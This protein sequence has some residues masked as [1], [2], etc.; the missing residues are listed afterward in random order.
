[1]EDALVFCNREQWHCWLSD[2]HDKVSSV[3][4]VFYKKCS[5]KSGITLDEAVEEALRFG[6]IDSRQ[7][8]RNQETFV[9]RFSPRKE[10]SLWSKINKARAEKLIASGKMTESGLK[11]IEEAQKNGYWENAYTNLTS[12]SLPNDLKDALKKDIKAWNN[13]NK[14]A[15]S[16]RN[17]Y[18]FWINQA[19][20]PQTRQKRIETVVEKSLKNIKLLN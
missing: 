7:R 18:I 16:Y 20:T 12:R 10:R 11:K 6:W 14:F 1:M 13:F 4:L 17:I 9:L 8:K 3:W 15:N 5:G 2:N 19:K